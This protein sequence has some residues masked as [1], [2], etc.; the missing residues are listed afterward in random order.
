MDTKGLTLPKPKDGKK[1]KKK[2]NHSIRD[3]RRSRGAMVKDLD[4]L[5]SREVKER[6]EYTCQRCGKID[7]EWD[8]GIEQYVV[9]QWAHIHT[10]EYHC[11]RWELENGLTLC[12]RCHVWFDNHKFLAYDWFEKNYPERYHMIRNVLLSGST[13]MSDA[14]VRALW[15]ARSGGR[16]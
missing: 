4:K 7:G 2:K 13:K 14:D 9:V 10:R 5:T 6:D 11:T 15:E 16:S 3:K 12:K 1:R 8:A